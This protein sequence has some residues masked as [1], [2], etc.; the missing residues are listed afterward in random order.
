M[1]PFKKVLRLLSE[2]TS[3][4]I[5]PNFKKQ[6]LNLLFDKQILAKVLDTFNIHFCL[7]KEAIIIRNDK[8][9]GQNYSDI[10]AFSHPQVLLPVQKEDTLLNSLPNQAVKHPGIS[11]LMEEI[12]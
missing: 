5:L 7:K 2:Q 12:S 1:E 4:P 3:D 9:D 8:L 6:R 10:D 11:Q